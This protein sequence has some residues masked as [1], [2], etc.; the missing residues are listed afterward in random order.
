M[1]LCSKIRLLMPMSKPTPSILL[2]AVQNLLC[3]DPKSFILG[4]HSGLLP[5]RGEAKD[6]QSALGM[7]FAIPYQLNRR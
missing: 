2:I 1:N 6:A 5:F 3:R 7:F 4:S